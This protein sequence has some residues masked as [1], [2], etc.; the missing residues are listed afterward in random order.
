M[1]CSRGPRSS[2]T[3]RRRHVRRSSGPGGRARAVEETE[4]A[5]AAAAAA[6]AAS[7]AAAAAVAVAA[8]VGEACSGLGADGRGVGGG[9]EPAGASVLEE[10]S[11]PVADGEVCCSDSSTN[12]HHR[13]HHLHHIHRR[14][15]HLHHHPQQQ[16]QTQQQQ[17]QQQQQPLQQQHCHRCHQRRD[18]VTA[19]SDEPVVDEEA[20]DEATC[21]DHQPADARH[22]DIHELRHLRRHH[23]HH[24]HHRHRHHCHVC[25]PHLRGAPEPP[26]HRRTSWCHERLRDDENGPPPNPDPSDPREEPRDDTVDRVPRTT[27]RHAD[28]TAADDNPATVTAMTRGCR[29]PPYLATLLILSYTLFGIADACSSRSTPKPRPPTPTPRPNIT[30]HMYTCPPDYAEWYCL[31]GATCFTVKIV[32]SLLYNCL[33]ANG[34]IG[35]R[36][37]FK[38]LDGSYLPSR[39]RVMLETAS[40]AGGATI[41]VFLVVIICIAAYIHCKRK[42]KELRSSNCVDT[43]DGPGRDPELRPFSNRSRSLM[44]FMTKNPNSL[45]AIEQTRMPGWSSPDAAESMRMASISEGKRSTQ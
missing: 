10:V 43:V 42:Q 8:G 11:S 4:E 2:S 20:D 6:R 14:Y 26:R 28:G 36:C 7:A 37:E 3:G 27:D 1:T 30:F 31:N 23:H 40:I 21:Q 16:Q 15:G 33:C 25:H 34:Y 18:S 12:Y 32:D 9:C 41:A 17:Q 24:L 35:Q 5:A 39:Q 45:A 13:A 19:S 38:D 44:I 22:R 29:I